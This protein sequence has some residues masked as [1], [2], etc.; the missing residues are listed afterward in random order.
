MMKKHTVTILAVLLVALGRMSIHAQNPQAASANPA[1]QQKA[2]PAA[3]TKIDPAKET[4]IRKL[5]DI[6]G[7]KT[8]ATQTMDAMLKSIKP[9]LAGNLPPGE[10]R[11]KLIELFFEKFHSKTD[12]QLLVDL[13]VPIYDKH[14]S[15]EEVKALIQ[16][17]ETP[18]GKKTLSALPAIANESR[19]AGEK[20]GAAVGQDCMREVLAEH[21][22]LAHA[23]EAAGKKA[24]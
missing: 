8:L 10:Y 13:V 22:D 14:L 23:M 11:E 17:Y 18:I 24:P 9:L 19:E 5:L 15:H 12:P 2:A 6:T 21:P 4:D 3:Q 1:A 20:W 16:F 7:A